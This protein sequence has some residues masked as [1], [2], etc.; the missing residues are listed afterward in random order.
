[1]GLPTNNGLRILETGDNSGDD[2]AFAADVVGDYGGLDENDS[3]RPDV[4]AR[5]EGQAL[6]DL[7]CGPGEG[8]RGPI[9][10]WYRLSP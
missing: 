3:P 7:R 9:R 10:V 2:V 8:A 6:L 5:L 1:M 4:R